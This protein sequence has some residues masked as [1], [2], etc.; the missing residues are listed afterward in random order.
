MLEKCLAFISGAF[1][2]SK[3]LFSEFRAI[4]VECTSLALKFS[5]NLRWFA[6]VNARNISGVYFWR[7][8]SAPNFLSA[9]LHGLV[10]GVD[11][12]SL[13]S[14]AQLGTGSLRSTMQLIDAISTLVHVFS[15][16]LVSLACFCTR[17]R[18]KRG[19]DRSPRSEVC[20]PWEVDRSPQSEIRL[21]KRGEFL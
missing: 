19:T 5:A 11:H 2:G 4:R 7:R 1:L 12:V 10:C 15:C 18:N 16:L 14:L 8:F 21:P 17:R 3:L 9:T 20:T 6:R 13:L